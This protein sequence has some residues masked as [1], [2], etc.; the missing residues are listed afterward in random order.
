[1]LS[2]RYDTHALNRERLAQGL[3]QMD[4]AQRSGITQASV[5]RIF[6]TQR[7][8]PKSAKAIAD[9]LGVDLREYITEVGEPR[10][11]RSVAAPR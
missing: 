5:S 10:P 4:L 8:T 2:M 11:E 6:L 7:A 1:M 3:T 9:A